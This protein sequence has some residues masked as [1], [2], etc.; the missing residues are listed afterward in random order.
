MNIWLLRLLFLLQY[1]TDPKMAKLT[2]VLL[3]DIINKSYPNFLSFYQVDTIVSAGFPVEIHDVTT[4]DGYV[5]TMHRIP[6]GRSG[7]TTERRPVV[8]LMHG[9]MSA[10]SHFVSLGADHSIGE[11]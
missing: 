9:I 6:Y 4:E 2:E 10:S 5:L 8:F 11:L 1:G 7:P 3:L